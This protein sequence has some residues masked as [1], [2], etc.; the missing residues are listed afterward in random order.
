MIKDRVGKAVGTT[1]EIISLCKEVNYG[2][3]QISNMLLLHRSIFIPRL[4]YNCETW[5]K[6]ILKDYASLR[7]SQLSFLR[8]ALEIPRS[9][10]T[11][12]LYLNLVFC[13]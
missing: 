7:K 9:V 3:N 12:A 13:P 2:K 6:V 5:T 11:A 4:I 10:P 1:N 8:R